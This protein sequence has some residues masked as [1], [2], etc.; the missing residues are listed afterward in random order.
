MGQHW[1][2]T[3]EALR[4]AKCIT[5]LHQAPILRAQNASVSLQL[6]TLLSPYSRECLN[7]LQEPGLD[8]SGGLF[9]SFMVLQAFPEGGFEWGTSTHIWSKSLEMLLS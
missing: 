4:L 6:R 2:S 5:T 7:L 1:E 8:V 9:V 3:E